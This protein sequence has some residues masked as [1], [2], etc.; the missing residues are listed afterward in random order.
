MLYHRRYLFLLLNWYLLPLPSE[1]RS[2]HR[3]GARR[4]CSQTDVDSVAKLKRRH[5]L[6]IRGRQTPPVPSD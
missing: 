1:S 3:L 4:A 2:V 5:I 6:D